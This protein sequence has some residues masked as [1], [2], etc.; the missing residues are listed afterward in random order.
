MG[1][2]ADLF[3]TAAGAVGRGPLVAAGR[4]QTVAG[5]GAH[6]TLSLGVDAPLARDG[7]RSAE[8]VRGTHAKARLLQHDKT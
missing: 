5:D 6:S 3:Q 4:G 8:R 2:V 7:P 1:V